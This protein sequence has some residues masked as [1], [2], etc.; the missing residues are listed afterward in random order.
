M[1]KIS[2]AEKHLF[3]KLKQNYLPNLIMSSSEFET[4]DC[5]SENEYG[6]SPTLYFELKCRDTHYDD[7]FIEKP[8]WESLMSKDGHAFYISET[9]NGCWIFNIK[10]LPEPMWYEKL[11][12]DSTKSNYG[13]HELVWKWVGKYN[14]AQGKKIF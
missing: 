13:N 6:Y 3:Q 5:Y 11:L 8:K 10:K 1:K 7:L 14:I 9:P 12:P 2:M 4:H